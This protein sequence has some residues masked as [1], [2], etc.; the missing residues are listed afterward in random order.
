MDDA[1][2]LPAVYELGMGP[3][4]LTT[5]T[6]GPIFALPLQWKAQ[7]NTGFGSRVS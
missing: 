4:S 6:Y 3:T 2:P 7:D 5:G 1:S